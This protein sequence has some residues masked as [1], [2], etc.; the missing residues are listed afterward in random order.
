VTT[1]AHSAARQTF[2]FVPLP[3]WRFPCFTPIECGSR[4][5]RHRAV[6][7]SMETRTALRHGFCCFFFVGVVSVRGMW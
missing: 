6:A 4:L 3:F 5:Q 7:A 1:A 2:P